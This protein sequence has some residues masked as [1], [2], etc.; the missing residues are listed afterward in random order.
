MRK[1][2]LFL[3]GM[4]ALDG[5]SAHTTDHA[6]LVLDSHSGRCLEKE[7]QFESGELQIS[8][9]YKVFS[10]TPVKDSAVF[11]TLNQQPI[12]KILPID[13]GKTIKVA[14]NINK[15][16]DR[17]GLCTYGSPQEPIHQ[18]QISNFAVSIR[19]CTGG[20]GND[21]IVNGGFE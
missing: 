9:D 2:F 17:I 6:S 13:N 21:L 1:A 15:G 20:W 18:V 16:T 10:Q 12:H 8:L 14:G 5:L 19:G 3:L 11:I 4:S 7:Y